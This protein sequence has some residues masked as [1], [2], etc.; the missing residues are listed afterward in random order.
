MNILLTDIKY[1][2]TVGPKRAELLGKELNILCYKDLLYFFPFRYVD[3]SKFYAISEIDSAN[4]YVQLRGIIKN[5][6]NIGEGRSRRLVASF[7]DDT[8]VIELVFFKGIKWISEKLKIGSEYIV[9]G[10]PSNFNG[11]INMVH[12]EI[13]E[14]LYPTRSKC[15]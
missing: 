4:A 5:I 10:K 11:N 1:L 9:F 2:P 8:G 3:R 7:S 12:P 15:V 13:E 14:V 6:S